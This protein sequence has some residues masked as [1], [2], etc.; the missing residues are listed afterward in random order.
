MFKLEVQ[1]LY[2]VIL[3]NWEGRCKRLKLIAWTADGAMAKA[4]ANGRN[5]GWVA[6]GVEHL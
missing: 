1:T 3:E 5:T 4:V 2:T 6:V